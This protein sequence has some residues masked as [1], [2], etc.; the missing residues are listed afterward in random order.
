MTEQERQKQVYEQ[1]MAK[2][3]EKERVE[4]G[5][6]GGLVAVALGMQEIDKL[7]SWGE[8]ARTFCFLFAMALPPFF[9]WAVLLE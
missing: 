5:F 6:A 8:W 2:I 4:Q 1:A 7:E 3:R 9:V